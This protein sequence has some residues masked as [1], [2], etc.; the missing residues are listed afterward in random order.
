MYILRQI[1]HDWPDEATIRILKSVRVAMGN[2]KCMLALVEVGHP[3]AQLPALLCVESSSLLML[4]KRAAPPRPLAVHQARPVGQE[5][6][7]LV[8]L[9]GSPWGSSASEHHGRAVLTCVTC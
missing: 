2:T 6:M 5:A 3:M 4:C 9:P 1:C 7:P 8:C